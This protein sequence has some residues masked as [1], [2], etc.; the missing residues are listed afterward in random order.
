[1]YDVWIRNDSNS[2]SSDLMWFYFR[3]KNQNNFIGKIRI[4]IVNM[5]KRLS[6]P[7]FVSNFVFKSLQGMRP[8][9][10]SKNS[11]NEKDEWQFGGSN[12][13]YKISPYTNKINW[14]NP[15]NMRTYY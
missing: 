11:C 12:F 9:F 1:V 4:N 8:V 13:E 3:M 7:Y 15:K 10:L 6:L 5:T 2:S 14:F